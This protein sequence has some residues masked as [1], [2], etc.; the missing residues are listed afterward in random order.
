MYRFGTLNPDSHGA[1]GLG[2]MRKKGA[3]PPGSYAPTKD[4]PASMERSPYAASVYHKRRIHSGDPDGVEQVAP[5]LSFHPDCGRI[6]SRC[7]AHRC[8][9]P[10]SH[11]GYCECATDGQVIGLVSADAVPMGAYQDANVLAA[12]QKYPQTWYYPEQPLLGHFLRER[13]R[14]KRLDASGLDGLNDDQQRMLL[15]E[16][17][18]GNDPRNVRPEGAADP[19]LREEPHASRASGPEA[20]EDPRTTGRS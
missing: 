9:F 3:A 17:N 13:L 8:S 6:C 1:A 11:D 20:H 4:G 7:Y 2:M 16:L 18:R 12:L 19:A 14:V 5:A 15:G 10:L